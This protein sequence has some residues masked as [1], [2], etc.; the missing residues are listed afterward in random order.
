MVLTNDRDL[1]KVVGSLSMF[2]P[3]QT[4]QLDI[5]GLHADQ[6]SYWQTRIDN[7]NMPVAAGKA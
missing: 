6:Q 4:I 7:T 5:L 3:A 1:K 2:V